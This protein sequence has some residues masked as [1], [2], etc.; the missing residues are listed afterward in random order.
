MTKKN[1]NML[2]FFVV[3]FFF[4]FQRFKDVTARYRENL[5]LVLKGVSFKVDAGEKIGICG[6]TGSGKS[7]LMVTLF[8]M[9]EIAE[10]SIGKN[11][12]FFFYF[13]QLYIM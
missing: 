5:E 3:W 4:L 6:R 11:F 9:I 12:Y 8:R 10:G 7:T 1:G 2:F 13:L